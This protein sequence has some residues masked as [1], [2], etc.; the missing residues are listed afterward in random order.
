MIP[1]PLAQLETPP[2]PPLIS[3]E[4]D[5]VAISRRLIAE[6]QYEDEDTR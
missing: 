3:T 4:H 6:K 2:P 1:A 5:F